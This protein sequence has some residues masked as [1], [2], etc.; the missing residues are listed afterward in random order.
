MGSAPE[1]AICLLRGDV[2]VGDTI[3]VDARNGELDVTRGP[4]RVRVMA[5]A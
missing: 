3:V 4:A 1:H 2:A 5:E